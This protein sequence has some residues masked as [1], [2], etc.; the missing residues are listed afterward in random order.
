[1]MLQLDLVSVFQRKFPRALTGYQ[2]YSFI[3]FSTLA[4]VSYECFILFPQGLLELL[5]C[6][7]SKRLFV[8]GLE[9]SVEISRQ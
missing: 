8:K 5:K 3:L 9:K 7:L 1:M 4:F 2:G 6:W